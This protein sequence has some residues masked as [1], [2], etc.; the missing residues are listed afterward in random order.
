MKKEEKEMIS[1]FEELHINPLFIGGVV[2]VLLTLL[3]MMI[4]FTNKM[5]N[6]SINQC[7]AAGYSETHCNTHLRG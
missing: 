5:Q 1:I 2:I 3:I 6:Q 7:V 4:V